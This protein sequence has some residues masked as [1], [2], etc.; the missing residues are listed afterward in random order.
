[1]SVRVRTLLI[2]NHDSFTFNLFQ[3]LAEVNGR[4]P[5]VVRNDTRWS[6][7]DVSGFDNIVISP[8]PGRPAVDRDVG[9][10]VR[11]VVDTALPLLGVCLGHQALCHLLGGQVAHASE[12]VH[13]RTSAV[14]HTGTG[15][16][17]G[18]P[19][20]FLAVRYHSLAVTEV[21][22]EL[23][24]TARTNDD[25]VMAV[26]QRGSPRWGVQF[27]PESIL[28]EHGRRLLANFRALTLPHARRHASDRQ[29]RAGQPATPTVG[30]E[31]RPGRSQVQR[32]TLRGWTDPATAFVQ[33]FGDSPEAFW[34]D[35][36]AHIPGR[37]RF[38]FM[39]DASGPL[40][41][42]VTYDVRRGLVTTRAAG[43]SLTRPGPLL[44]HLDR[45]LRERRVPPADLPFQ[46]GYVGFLGY[47]LKAECGGRDR[48]RAQTPDAAMIF[49]DRLVVF[50]HRDREIHLLCLVPAPGA[51]GWIAHTSRRLSDLADTSGERPRP[52]QGRHAAVPV[53]F[54]HPPGEYLGLIAECQ[55]EI[56]DG[57]SYEICLTNMLRAQT[58]VDPMRTYLHYRRANPAPY[59][60]FLRFGDLAVLSASPE[61]FL[62]V[63]TDG[64]VESQP[65]KGTRP[66]GRT[67]PE[68]RRLAAELRGSAKDRAENLMIVDL[69]RNDLGAVC[70]IGSVHAPRLFDVE[71]YATVHQ[72]VST[73]RG[74]LRSDATAIDAVRSAFPGGSMTGAPK[75][76]TMEI[77]DRL[78]DGPR[79]V[80]SGAL[81]YLGLGG[82]ADLSI[83]IRTMVVTPGDVGIGVGGA[84][85]AQS[86]RRAELEEAMLKGKAALGT[87]AATATRSPALR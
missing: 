45:R 7:V 85:V 46:L 83:V 48:H 2:D 29:R 73:V 75:L 26:R 67:G 13:G 1:M 47:E 60:A 32:R 70:E 69:A 68:D 27:H 58:P 65:I 77:I 81:G 17:D 43:A 9:I 74:R 51:A 39:G 3:L 49:A 54:R 41:E 38:S 72:L 22:G 52:A 23:Q 44:D 25:V 42:V 20:P 24:V 15:L 6:D 5:T 53:S 36:S 86:D 37:S 19:S 84:I 12:P 21:P 62:R 34:L 11:A 14:H 40:S 80:Y 87:L 8:G 31:D 56:R 76:R 79:G 57:E 16:F 10:S 64:T 33:L 59:G 28:T 30:S 61:R 66:R 78:E 35:S 4:P 50:D 71:S 82:T 63:T 55:R 18:I